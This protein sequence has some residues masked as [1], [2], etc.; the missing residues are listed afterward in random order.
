MWEKFYKNYYVYYV[1]DKKL[2][3]RNVETRRSQAVQT[4]LDYLNKGRSAQS[5]MNLA[6]AVQLYGKGLEALEPWLFMDLT[7]EP[8]RAFT[9]GFM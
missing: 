8:A 7:V 6:Q 9:M 3:A 5:T 2:Y 1:L 4:G